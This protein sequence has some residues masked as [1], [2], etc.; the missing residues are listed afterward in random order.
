MTKKNRILIIDDEEDIGREIAGY[1]N[2]SGYTAAYAVSGKDGL[3]LMQKDVP[4][5]LILDIQ[6]PE[7]DGIEVI[8]E[9]V[10][11]FPTVKVLIFTGFRD[12]ILAE[13]A[14]RYGALEVIIKPVD[15]ETLLEKHIRPALG[16]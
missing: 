6:M 4:D 7:I 13:K 8:R 14:I 10:R 15:A 3:A 11:R 9:I 2:D 12:L 16:E 5:L 1:L